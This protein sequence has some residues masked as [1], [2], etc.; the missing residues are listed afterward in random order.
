[1]NLLRGC[2]MLALIP[3][4]ASIARAQELQNYVISVCNTGTV[5]FAVASAEKKPG[6]WVWSDYSWVIPAARRAWR[7]PTRQSSP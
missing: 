4:L 6:D 7:L 5:V 1:M 2:L 3:L